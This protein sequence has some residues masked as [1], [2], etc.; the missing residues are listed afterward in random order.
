L[1]VPFLIVLPK[2]SVHSLACDE[3]SRISETGCQMSGC[4][5]LDALMHLHHD[6]DIDVDEICTIFVIKHERRMF[7]VNGKRPI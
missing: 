2:L 7:Q 1:V 5:D 4:Q 6:L 3:L